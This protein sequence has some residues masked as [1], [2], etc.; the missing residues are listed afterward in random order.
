MPYGVSKDVGGDSV[1]NV[2]KIESCVNQ[3]TAKGVEK[4]RAIAICKSSRQK[5]V[6]RRRRRG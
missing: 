4:S 1:A 6:R 2:A 5:A 3:L